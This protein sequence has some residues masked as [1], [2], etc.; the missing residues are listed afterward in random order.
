[1]NLVFPPVPNAYIVHLAK[2]QLHMTA[3][4]SIMYFRHPF[5]T[6][7]TA[8][9]II[10]T[11]AKHYFVF[12]GDQLRFDDHLSDKGFQASP[13]MF[14]GDIQQIGHTFFQTLLILTRQGKE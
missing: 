2:N 8:A 11:A 9:L 4:T 14:G 6:Q 1:M 3:R 7:R 13:A 10:L 5:M 12:F